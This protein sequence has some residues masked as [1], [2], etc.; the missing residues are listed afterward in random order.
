M[1]AATVLRPGVI[2]VLYAQPADTDGNAAGPVLWLVPEIGHAGQLHLTDRATD[3]AV[4]ENLHRSF[5]GP[6]ATIKARMTECG[7]IP[8]TVMHDAINRRLASE[9]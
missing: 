6:Y 9:V 5:P 4:S 1:N 3:E 7:L 2:E 8:R